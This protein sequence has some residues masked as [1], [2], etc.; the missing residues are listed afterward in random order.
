L[1]AW[2]LARKNREGSNRALFAL[3]VVFSASPRMNYGGILIPKRCFAPLRQL[4]RSEPSLRKTLTV[5]LSNH[6]FAIEP[7]HG[8]AIDLS[9]GWSVAA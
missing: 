5:I 9:P 7:S 3:Q 8:V 1:V 2:S 4:R 6:A